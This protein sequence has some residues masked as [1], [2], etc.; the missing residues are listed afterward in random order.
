MQ[1]LGPQVRKQLTG[2]DNYAADGSEAF[3][4]LTNLTRL[5]PEEEAKQL[6]KALSHAK[7]YLKAEYKVR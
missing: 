5:F 7:H 4:K 2:L 1:L 3:E 6:K